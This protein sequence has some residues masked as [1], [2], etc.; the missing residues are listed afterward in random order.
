MVGVKQRVKVL[1]RERRAN[2]PTQ[3]VFPKNGETQEEAKAR[4]LAE[5][6][7]L[8]EELIVFFPPGL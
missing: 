6:H 1:E 8:D 3:I 2:K 7:V 5:G 4:Y